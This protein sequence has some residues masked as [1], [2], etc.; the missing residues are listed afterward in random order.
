MTF[1]LNKKKINLEL[2]ATELTPEQIR[3]VKT[4][5]SMLVHVLTTDEESEF[6]DGSA[7]FMKTAAKLI[8]Q[9]HFTT[10]LVD[11]DNIPYAEQA[12]EYSMDIL[13][14]QICGAKYMSYDN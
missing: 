2:D 5:N 10:D 1:G 3:L 13:Q 9:A 7:E 8:K 6:F 12:L 4:L 11:V 14:E